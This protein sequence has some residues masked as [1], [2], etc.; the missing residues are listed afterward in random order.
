VVTGGI[1]RVVVW[2]MLVQPVDS[3]QATSRDVTYGGNVMVVGVGRAR[4][5]RMKVHGGWQLMTGFA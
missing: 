1:V 5:G 3:D 4:G 2:T